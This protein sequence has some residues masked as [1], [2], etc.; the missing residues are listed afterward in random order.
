MTVYTPLSNIS[1][2][3]TVGITSL[4]VPFK[5]QRLSDLTVTRTPTGLAGA[6]LSQGTD[7]LYVGLGEPTGSVTL[8]TPSENGDFYVITRTVP[9]IQDFNIRNTGAYHPANLEDALDRLVT[10]IQQHSGTGLGSGPTWPVI[11]GPPPA[12]SAALANTPIVVKY[13]GGPSVVMIACLQSD[14]V[15]YEWIGLGSTSN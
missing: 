13:P 10:M 5:I 12:P 14:D 11:V 1:Y 6:E 15:T 7:Y 4:P 8:A 2:T 9:E 3:T